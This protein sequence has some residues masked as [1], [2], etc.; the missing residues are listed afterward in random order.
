[1]TVTQRL[2]FPLFVLALF[3]LVAPATAQNQND[4]AAPASSSQPSGDKVTIPDGTTIQLELITPINTKMNQVGDEVIAQLKDSLRVDGKLVFPRGT[5]FKGEIKE[6]TSAKVGQR[7]ANLK[8]VFHTAVT[9]LGTQPI[10]TIV[11]SADDYQHEARLKADQDGKLSGGHSGGRTVNNAIKGGWL[12]GI[13]AGVIGLGGGG[14]GA[15]AGTLGG[16]TG[17]GVLLTKGNDIN[18]QQNTIIRIRFNKPTTVS[19]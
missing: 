17:A 5:E 2:R 11:V 3:F 10:S 6:I 19:L 4:P 14:A 12:G 18:L 9:D 8:I 7:A 15:A 13:G 1:M 16:A